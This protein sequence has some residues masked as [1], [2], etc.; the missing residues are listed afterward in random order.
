MTSR[1]ASTEHSAP[2][3]PSRAPDE[4]EAAFVAANAMPSP[5]VDLVEPIPGA[6][7]GYDNPVLFEVPV[8]L[9]LRAVNIA[10]IAA[11]FAIVL[12]TAAIAFVAVRT[13]N[14]IDGAASGRSI[15]SAGD[16]MTIVVLVG[17]VLLA[18]A[19]AAS[20]MWSR[21]VAENT[22]RLRGRWPSLNR[23]TRVWFYPTVWV[24][25]A[26]LTFLR[27]EVTGEFNPLPA[28]AAIVFALTLYSPFSMLHRI[29]K[30][31]TRVRPDG[32]IRAAYLLD[33]AGFGIIWW[34]LTDWPDPITPT[35]SGTV[36]AMAW[37]A[38]AS[39]GLLLISAGITANLAHQAIVAQQYRIRVLATRHVQGLAL[40]LVPRRAWGRVR[41][42][43]DDAATRGA[44]P[45]GDVVRAT[46]LVLGPGGIPS[47]AVVAARRTVVP[48]R[49]SEAV[50]RTTTTT[51]DERALPRPRL[52]EGGTEITPRR[53]V[54]RDG[55]A[56][57]TRRRPVPG[58]A[59][60]V[61]ARRRPP[62]AGT[63]GGAADGAA[64]ARPGVP[65]TGTG[66]PRGTTAAAA[67]RRAST[68]GAAAARRTATTGAAASRRVAPPGAAAAR[69][70]VTPGAAGA[71]VAR[72]RAAATA[73]GDTA[74]R[75]AVVAEAAARRRAASGHV[76][77]P[78][79][80]PDVGGPSPSDETP[81]RSGPVRA[82][83]S[84]D[85]GHDTPSQ[86]T[87]RQQTPRQQ[88]P[89]HDTTSEVGG[90]RFVDTDEPPQPTTFVGV[91]RFLALGAHVVLAATF[92]W[93]VVEARSATP[94]PNGGG[95]E[96][97]HL[98]RL[99]LVR[100][101]NVVALAVTVLLIGA[102]GSATSMLA[103]R[104]NRVAPPPWLVIATCVPA[105]LFVLAGLVI[106]GRVGEGVV[107]TLGV[108]AAGIGG[109]SSLGLMS[110]MSR[111]V[112]DGSRGLQIWA[113]VIAVVGLG[114][115]IGGYLRSIGPDDSSD[116]LTLVAV[117]T[118]ILVG[119]AVLL[120][121]PASGELD[122][123]VDVRPIVS[124]DRTAGH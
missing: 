83:R 77:E 54:A 35:D 114:L 55:E 34:R 121:A 37:A 48:G 111:E 93:F 88:T 112:E 95:L 24:A 115:T 102:W 20:V 123:V 15:A 42:N 4:V 104:S 82:A 81:R 58:A 31:L 16:D 117:L 73:S 109:A 8:L 72:R 52:A 101:A 120:G 39:S 47:A 74:A 67:A 40:P 21:T 64:R 108:L 106:D 56:P 59:G 94:D 30:T 17:V 122:D 113:A 90:A 118:S 78:T 23:A 29:F 62:V 98:D 45:V 11:R 36:D 105:T 124:P 46:D 44:G 100:T 80:A 27:V 103:R 63:R 38:I 79:L 84:A 91:L 65:Q 25:L 7:P 107:F 3:L 5:Q 14:R 32:A 60:Q 49:G 10:W 110:M 43:L 66:T 92:V 85:A 28:I 26:A 69:R 70:V 12:W 6:K 19:F 119:L 116:T 71:A 76:A 53:A 41:T 96:P 33:L 9:P 99:D 86:Q 68:T 13:T 75:R 57:V 89:R 1:A 61:A 50:A 87:P 97:S 18:A 51:T 2:R 22:R